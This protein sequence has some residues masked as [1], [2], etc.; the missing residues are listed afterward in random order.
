M[1]DK[2]DLVKYFQDGY[3][4]IDNLRI[5]VEHEKFLLNKHS[6]K[7]LSYTG[8]NGIEDI[9]N[10]F[11]II[12]N[13]SFKKVKHNM[14]CPGK[15][16][17]IRLKNKTIG[18][19]GEL[20]PEI[21]NELK[22]DSNPVMFELDYDPLKMNQQIN[23]YP[24]KYF[25]YSRRDLSILM[26]IDMEIKSIIKMIDALKIKDLSNI[27]IFDVY[28]DDKISSD[29]KSVAL[30]LIFQS[31]SRTLKDDEIDKYMIRINQLI[32]KEMNLIIR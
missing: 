7:P 10:Q 2:K 12:G 23:H 21:S 20:N 18:F 30:G 22:L 19:V 28:M 27:I 3:K 1:I 29:K 32:L 11:Q 4:T 8:V 16:A 5:G 31:K 13:I 24:S 14:L 6:L 17:S 25:P 9:F 15:S 26:D